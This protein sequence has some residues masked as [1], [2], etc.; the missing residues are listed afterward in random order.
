M[1]D[2]TLDR[3]NR[4]NVEAQPAAAI[5]RLA[6]NILEQAVSSTLS[7]NFAKGAFY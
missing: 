4:N 3:S 2:A 7:W 1:K 6:D 5:W